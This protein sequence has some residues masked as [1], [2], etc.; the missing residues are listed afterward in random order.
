MNAA[1]QLV[2]QPQHESESH[3]KPYTNNGALNN[4]SVFELSTEQRLRRAMNYIAQL[5]TEIRDL[6]DELNRAERASANNELLLRNALVREMEL[7]SQL[8]KDR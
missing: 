6:R 3:D 5:E 4:V 7:R 8:G 2:N 1:I